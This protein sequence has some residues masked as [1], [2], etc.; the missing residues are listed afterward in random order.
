MVQKKKYIKPQIKPMHKVCPFG[1]D[2]SKID[3][4]SYDK[5][6]KY[7]SVRGRILPKKQTGLS[8]VCQRK[9]ALTLKRARIIGLMPFVKYD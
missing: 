9:L 6:K 4:K 7:T 5:L 2:A 3:Y 1:G 8:A